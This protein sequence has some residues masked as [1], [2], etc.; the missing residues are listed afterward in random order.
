MR[1]HMQAHSGPPLLDCGV[2]SGLAG[3]Y[4]GPPARQAAPGE[5][6][7]SL[8]NSTPARTCAAAILKALP[9][10]AAALFTPHVDPCTMAETLTLRGELKGHRGWVTAIAPPLDPSSDVLVS[11]SR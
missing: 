5:V 9:G 1:S 8:A 2:A 3:P 11:S 6:R 7:A 10:A 4:I